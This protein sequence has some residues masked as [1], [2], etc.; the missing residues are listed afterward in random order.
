MVIKVTNA[1]VR[2]DSRCRPDEVESVMNY[3]VS[4]KTGHNSGENQRAW[5]DAEP[6]NAGDPDCDR[7]WPR[8]D[9]EYRC[10]VAMVRV[11][12]WAHEGRHH[13]GE[14][15]VNRIFQRR[16]DDDTREKRNQGH[17]HVSIV[18]PADPA[19]QAELAKFRAY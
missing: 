16:P 17:V 13:V 4:E 6:H 8:A 14:P 9:R 18:N 15:S 7:R 19:R 5:A 3:F 10:R 1:Q 2:L 12:D 11:V